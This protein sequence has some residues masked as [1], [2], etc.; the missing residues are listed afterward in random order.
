VV[1][2]ESVRARLKQSHQAVSNA[3]SAHHFLGDLCKFLRCT[4]LAHIAVNTGN[5]VVHT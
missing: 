5:K 4:L 2:S 3:L 1:E